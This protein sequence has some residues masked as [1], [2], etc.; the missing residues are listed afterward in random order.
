MDSTTH[1]L[2][3]AIVAQADRPGV[4]P[5]QSLSKNKRAQETFAATPPNSLYVGLLPSPELL[6]FQLELL[7]AGHKCPASLYEQGCNVIITDTTIIVSDNDGSWYA[8]L[9]PGQGRA[10]HAAGWAVKDV[11]ELPLSHRVGALER[12]RDADG[13]EHFLNPVN[14]K[15]AYIE[16]TENRHWVSVNADDAQ[17]Q[18]FANEK[19]AL[20]AAE[21]LL[22]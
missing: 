2:H 17:L 5:L 4:L 6:A 13:V 21:A 12:Y 18:S 7:A 8:T 9:A 14:R 10:G 22:A 19:D 11:P 1:A 16:E 20:A 3:K 15:E